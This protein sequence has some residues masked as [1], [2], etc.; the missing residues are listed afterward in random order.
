MMVC[1]AFLL[2]HIDQSNILPFLPT[3]NQRPLLHRPRHEIVLAHVVVHGLFESRTL[4]AFESPKRAEELRQA[5][6]HDHGG[7]TGILRD[8]YGVGSGTAVGLGGEFP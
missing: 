6:M 1:N 4:L 7:G 2:A 3:K 8:C 5:G